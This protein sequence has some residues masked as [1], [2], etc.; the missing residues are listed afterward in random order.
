MTASAD[1]DQ[2]K[3][4]QVTT[5]PWVYAASPDRR[6]GA[7][8]ISKWCGKWL[9]FIPAPH[10][11]RVWVQVRNATTAGHLGTAAKCASASQPANDRGTVVMCVYTADCRDL[12]DVKRVLAALRDLGHQG[13]LNYKEDVATYAGLYANDSTPASLYTSAAGLAIRTLRPVTVLPPGAVSQDR[14]PNSGRVRQG[15]EQTGKQRTA[16]LAKAIEASAE[17]EVVEEIRAGRLALADALADDRSK[18][19]RVVQLLGAMPGVGAVRAGRILDAARIDLGK[20]VSGLGAR[21]RAALLDAV[22]DA[23]ASN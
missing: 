15:A 23:A 17:S 22:D 9:L 14:Y 5:D 13:R 2:R 1:L 11:D 4:S 18:R 8:G 20:R 16:A 12:A 10:A 21:Q 3:P 19:A 7:V 6:A